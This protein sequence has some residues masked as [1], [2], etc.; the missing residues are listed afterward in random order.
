MKKLLVILAFAAVFVVK[1][2]PIEAKSFDSPIESVEYLS[3]E[4]LE[5]SFEVKA[6]RTEIHFY[7]NAVNFVIAESQIID[8]GKRRFTDMELSKFSLKASSD[9]RNNVNLFVIKPDTYGLRPRLKGHLPKHLDPDY[10]YR[11]LKYSSGFST[12]GRAST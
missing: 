11:H 3:A 6:D 8:V 2:D 4:A 5:V 9:I 12:F 10:P 7:H 1:A